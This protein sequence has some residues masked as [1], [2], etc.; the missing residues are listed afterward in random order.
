MIESE[1]VKG[2]ILFTFMLVIKRSLANILLKQW[3]IRETGFELN[4]SVP[5][6]FRLIPGQ[7]EDIDNSF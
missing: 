3:N 6:F 5:F 2:Y 7:T 4:L 1:G